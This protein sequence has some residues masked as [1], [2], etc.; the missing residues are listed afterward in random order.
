LQSTFKKYA[1][2]EVEAAMKEARYTQFFGI[3]ELKLSSPDVVKGVA[4][5]MDLDVRSTFH[6]LEVIFAEDP[7]RIVKVVKNQGN[8]EELVNSLLG[9]FIKLYTEEIVT[10]YQI[11]SVCLSAYHG[12]IDVSYSPALKNFVDKLNASNSL[13]TKLWQQYKDLGDQTVPKAMKGNPS[14]CFVTKSKQEYWILMCI[15]K[16]VSTGLFTI[17]ADL[18]ED[19]FNTFVDQ[20]FR[21]AS[22]GENLVNEEMSDFNFSRSEAYIDAKE[23]THFLS[24][25]ILIS[26]LR[27]SE[28]LGSSTSLV[29]GPSFSTLKII[30][31]KSDGI[32]DKLIKMADESEDTLLRI[33]HFALAFAQVI[34][35]YGSLVQRDP[36]QK[37]LEMKLAKIIHKNFRILDLSFNEPI[38][39][40]MN[41]NFYLLFSVDKEKG[42]IKKVVKELITLIIMPKSEVNF[43]ETMSEEDSDCVATSLV[44]CLDSAQELEFF[45]STFDNDEVSRRDITMVYR[46]LVDIFPLRADITLK[47]ALKLSGDEYY[48]FAWH[49]MQLFSDLASFTLVGEDARALLSDSVYKE[50]SPGLN[51]FDNGRKSHPNSLIPSFQA[52][53]LFEELGHERIRVKQRFNMWNLFWTNMTSI[54][55]LSAEKDPKIS[56]TLRGMLELVCKVIQIEPRLCIMFQQL[57]LTKDPEELLRMASNDSS[58]INHLGYSA[59]ILL[60]LDI[61]RDVKFRGEDVYLALEILKALNA[62][63][64]SELWRTT[65]FAIQIHD[66]LREQEAE[67]PLLPS[68]IDFF[69]NKYFG[70]KPDHALLLE[71]IVIL[72]EIIIRKSNYMFDYFPNENFLAM[73]S[74]I[75]SSNDTQVVQIVQLFA[76]KNH[77][78]SFWEENLS[79]QFN[80]E[81]QLY[82]AEDRNEAKSEGLQIATTFL[83]NLLMT[84]S[85]CSKIVNSSI[86]KC[87]C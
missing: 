72:T 10:Q 79:S 61:L 23:R 51:V 1:A 6:L 59:L 31:D 58:Q 27:I 57:M 50:V 34:D 60:L 18:Y 52:G 38:S 9:P 19:M 12:P 13:L 62:L 20:D 46:N 49:I 87:I 8:S 17:D 2:G 7:K 35:Y 16:G 42:M 75:D 5:S 81:I 66:A 25:L 47:L 41:S 76:E 37:N 65:F 36:S 11:I 67:G 48:P 40:L 33:A 54:V 56:S 15:F 4:E 77:E 83:E 44:S 43:I 30:C 64:K 74:R 80:Q 28:L 71:Q 26:G 78:N 68:L 32:T 85:E 22:F 24:S 55:R 63:M 29:T 53:T 39:L 69:K 73:R 14:D 84:F 86:S 45:W 70:H 21:G 82:F 3:E